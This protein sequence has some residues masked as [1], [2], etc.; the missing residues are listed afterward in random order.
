MGND[1]KLMTPPSVIDSSKRNAVFVTEDLDE[2]IDTAFTIHNS[3]QT[4]ILGQI[5]YCNIALIVY[6]YVVSIDR[7]QSP[8]VSLL[9]FIVV[10][11]PWYLQITLNGG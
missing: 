8:K 9:I 1:E 10:Y 3:R 7:S 11:F 4:D 5:H 6:D 2:S